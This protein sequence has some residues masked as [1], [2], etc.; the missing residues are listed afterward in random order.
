MAKGKKEI[1]ITSASAK[2]EIS[3]L[4]EKGGYTEAE[5]IEL[6]IWDNTSEE[7]EESQKMSDGWKEFSRTAH[8]ARTFDPNKPKVDRVRAEN[9]TKRS[10]I[11]FLN[12][13]LE[14]LEGISNL[15]IMNPEKYITFEMDGNKY[16]LNLIQKRPP[17]K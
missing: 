14:A 7:T 1:D 15:N 16:E 11:S 17:K 5:A 13:G 3:R 2:A 4:M 8:D 10:I 6:Y 9:P 12:V